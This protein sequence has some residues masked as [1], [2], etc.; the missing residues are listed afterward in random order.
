MIVQS[1]EF[2][3]S[4]PNQQNIAYL[5]LIEGDNVLEKQLLIKQFKTEHLQYDWS[6]CDFTKAIICGFDIY[7]CWLVRIKSHLP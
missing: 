7:Q 3:Y 6:A 1:I 2:K 5:T 4:A